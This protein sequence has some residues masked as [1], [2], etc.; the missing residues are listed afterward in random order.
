VRQRLLSRQRLPIG[1]LSGG[2]KTTGQTR[3]CG[4]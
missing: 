3:G 1:L 2:W 4:R